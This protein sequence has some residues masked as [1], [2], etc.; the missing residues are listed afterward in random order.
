MAIETFIRYEKK[1][2]L[3]NN[4]FD[5]LKNE[6]EK[7]MVYDEYCLNGKIYSIYNIYF[8]DDNNSVVQHSVSKPYFKDKLRIRSY[9]EFPEENDLIFLELKKKIGG[10]VTKRRT[11]LSLN[12]CY[13]YINTGEY[14]P[15]AETNFI[16]NQVLREVDYFRKLYDVKP[17]T[18]LSYDRLA[19]FD[20]NDTEFRITFDKRITSRR[21]DLNLE[22]GSYGEELLPDG[23][24]VM[25]I[26]I[27]DSMPMWCTHLLSELE[28]YPR[29]FSKYGYDYKKFMT[30]KDNINYIM[31]VV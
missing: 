26:K 25:E 18:Y 5:I 31:E 8:D 28:I 6:I 22:L 13:K 21:T 23:V 29:G 14:P 24:M 17:M 11:E 2:L 10:I 15:E 27:H 30:E 19:Y 7:Y 1:Y 16:M 12:D 9:K 20:E 4:Q 3:T